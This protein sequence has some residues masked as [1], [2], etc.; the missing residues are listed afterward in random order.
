[1]PKL[2]KLN[3]L[4]TK[5]IRLESFYASRAIIEREDEPMPL[6]VTLKDEGYGADQIANDGIYS[7]YFTQHSSQNN[8]RYTL[9][10][11]VVGDESTSVVQ[12][13]VRAIDLKASKSYPLNPHS[14][15]QTNPICCGSSIGED[16]VTQPT[17]EFTRVANGYSFRVINPPDTNQDLYPPGQVTD[18]SVQSYASGGFSVIEFTATGDDY[19]FGT[20]TKYEI[21]YSTNFTAIRDPDA[22][23]EL[24]NIT[25]SEL[26]YGNLTPIEAGLK[27]SI[28]PIMSIFGESEQLY[29]IAMKVFDEQ[30][31]SDLSNIAQLQRWIPPDAIE[32]LNVDISTGI[33]LSFTMPK[34][35]GEYANVS[36]LELRCSNQS[37][38]LEIDWAGSFQIELYHLIDSSGT[39]LDPQP[40]GTSIQVVVDP[41]I[42][43]AGV[44]YTFGIKSRGRYR[45][46]SKLSNLVSM[47]K[48]QG[49]GF[50]GGQITGIVI[51]SLLIGG[52]VVSFIAYYIKNNRK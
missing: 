25:E 50:S 26:V 49:S 19:D 37:S 14:P 22:W 51:G 16:I 31:A 12:E 27:M 17:G 41:S 11:Q 39:W 5:K 21:R 1:M 13:K 34:D 23:N 7:R 29:Y 48:P 3:L 43:E 30:Q 42:F 47:T 44:S 2:S 18:L 46:L 52:F 9:R 4:I 28:E 32:D 24:P 35:N 33:T 36:S 40:P 15:V 38:Q 10:C 20:A 6:T 8:T 45:E